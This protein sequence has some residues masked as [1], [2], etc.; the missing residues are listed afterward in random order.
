MGWEIP[1]L[2]RIQAKCDKCSGKENIEPVCT[3]SGQW[4]YQ[5][6]G[7]RGSNGWNYDE[8]GD[9]LCPA[10]HETSTVL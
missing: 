3:P 8:N 10:C 4:F 5:E 9:L 7:E 2:P 1:Q 6:P